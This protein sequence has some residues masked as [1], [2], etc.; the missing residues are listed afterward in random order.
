MFIYS[1]C[2]WFPTSGHG[3]VEGRYGSDVESR[4]GFMENMYEFF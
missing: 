1:L 4:E 2:Q 3:P